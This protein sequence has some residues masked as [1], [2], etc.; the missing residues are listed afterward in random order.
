MLGLSGTF[1][2]KA[3]ICLHSRNVETLPSC[4]SSYCVLSLR[5]TMGFLLRKGSV[6][7]SAN[8]LSVVYAKNLLRETGSRAASCDMHGVRIL[9]RALDKA[10]PEMEWAVGWPCSHN[11]PMY[12]S[13]AYSIQ[14]ERSGEFVGSVPCARQ[15]MHPKSAAIGIPKRQCPNLL[16]LSL[17]TRLPT[18]PQFTRIW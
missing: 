13:R 12:R 17:K 9:V 7:K 16:L 14:L 3:M 2:T 10:N 11:C 8:M 5:L 6:L 15:P 4:V 18:E 1:H